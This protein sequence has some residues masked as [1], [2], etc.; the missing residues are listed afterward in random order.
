[1]LWWIVQR[2][3]SYSVEARKEMRAAVVWGIVG[4]LL[5]ATGHVL[6]GVAKRRKVEMMPLHIKRCSLTSTGIDDGVVTRNVLAQNLSVQNRVVSPTRRGLSIG[7]LQGCT[8]KILHYT[9]CILPTSQSVISWSPVLP[10]KCTVFGCHPTAG[11]NYCCG[12]DQKQLSR[13]QG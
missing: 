4:W 6:C 3:A 12:I 11:R 9:L 13:S 10:H 5:H 8:K 7:K 2:S 1:M